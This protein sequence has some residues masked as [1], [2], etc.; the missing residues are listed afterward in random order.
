MN[1]PNLGLDRLLIEILRWG[2]PIILMIA[3]S[4][5]AISQILSERRNLNQILMNFAGTVILAF[6][7]FNL[8]TIVQWIMSAVGRTS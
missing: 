1:L 6:V 7:L 2:L 4:V 3:V 5:D 8:P